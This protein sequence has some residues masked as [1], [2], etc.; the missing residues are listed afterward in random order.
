M[1]SFRRDG[2]LPSSHRCCLMCLR[3]WQHYA[4][5]RLR[6][7]PSFTLSSVRPTRDRCTTQAGEGA[8]DATDATD[9]SHELCMLG[10]LAHEDAFPLFASVTA[11]DDGYK[12]DAL[13]YV[14]E[15]FIDCNCD[16]RVGSAVAF[17]WWPTVRFCASHY[18]YTVHAQSGE[19]VVVQTGV[20]LTHKPLQRMSNALHFRVPLVAAAKPPTA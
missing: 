11:T 17:Q 15:K 3:Y 6:L 4:Y 9:A 10:R 7:D 19:P 2:T 20:D 8:T 13:L 1:L 12:P 18:T 14:D 5:L 16:A